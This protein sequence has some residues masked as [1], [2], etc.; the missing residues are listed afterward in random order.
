MPRL[1]VL[2]RQSKVFDLVAQGKTYAEI[3]AALQISEDTVARDMAAIGEQVRELSRERLGEVL[4]VALATYQRVLDE[5]WREYRA[6]M[7]RERDWYA[8]RLDYETE[9]VATKTLALDEG[10]EGDE[11][12][13]R[14]DRSAKL[15]SRLFTQESEPIEIKRTVRVIR[16]GL[17]GE[18]RARWLQMIVE[19]T[20]ELTELLGIKKLV[21]EHQGADG[22]PLFKVYV[23][24]DVDQV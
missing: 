11:Q 18:G 19:T 10:D 23:G 22:G 20:R 17:R 21:I 5:A 8:G 13:Q 16:P 3:C 12:P 1:P 2:I 6:D 14:G 24:I 9:A 7:Q 15:A 4:A